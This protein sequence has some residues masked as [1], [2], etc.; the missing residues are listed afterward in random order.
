MRRKL[1]KVKGPTTN[2]ISLGL[3]AKDSVYR[4]NLLQKMAFLLSLNAWLDGTLLN[5]S[6]ASDAAEMAT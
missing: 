3:S 2:E 6:E 5:V 1:I 4:K